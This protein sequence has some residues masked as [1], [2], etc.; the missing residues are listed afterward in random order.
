MN[1]VIIA[2]ALSLQMHYSQEQGQNDV[3]F[4]STKG[5]RII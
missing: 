2:L 4:L 3:Y 1:F 5:G